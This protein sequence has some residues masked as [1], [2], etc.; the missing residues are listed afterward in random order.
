[1]SA[2]D[3]DIQSGWRDYVLYGGLPLIFSFET[4]DQKSDFLKRLLDETYLSDI[5][6]RNDIRNKAE[7]EEL[8]NILS[9][10]MGSLTNATKLSNTF[11][12]V[13]HKALSQMTSVCHHFWAKWPN[14]S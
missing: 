7:L 11:K 13:K 6:G 4:P 2:Y 5:I 14:F 1:M 10:S 8:L 3:G 9:S 12:S